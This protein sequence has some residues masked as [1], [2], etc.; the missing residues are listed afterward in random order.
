VTLKDGFVFH[1]GRLDDLMKLGG[2]WVSPI[3][4]EHVLR[5][6]AD[7]ADVAV[8]PR[9]NADGAVWLCAFLVSE[10]QDEA[11]VDELT[12]LCS[13]RLSSYKVPREWI[14]SDALPR[15]RTGK[16]RRLTLRDQLASS[17]A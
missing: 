5:G 12:M 15:T 2:R 4:V 11:L 13:S 16:L 6:H 1:Q 9:S 7:L 3:E 17:G 10:R 14:R 8:V